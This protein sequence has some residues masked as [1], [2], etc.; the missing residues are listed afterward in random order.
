MAV[1]RCLAVF[2]S[3]GD[4]LP[5]LPDHVFVTCPSSCPYRSEAGDIVLNDTC[6]L[7]YANVQTHIFKVRSTHLFFPLDVLLLQVGYI[8]VKQTSVQYFR[9]TASAF[10]HL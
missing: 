7:Q 1:D 3:L 8:G 9:K 2:F 4:E 5:V 6:I 10:L